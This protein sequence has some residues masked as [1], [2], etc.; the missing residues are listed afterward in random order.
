MLVPI[1]ILMDDQ[2][3]SSAFAGE[4][5]TPSDRWK[6]MMAKTMVVSPL[7]YKESSSCQPVLTLSI[8]YIYIYIYNPFIFPSLS[9]MQT[10]IT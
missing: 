9:G 5:A 4:V 8:A 2:R 7:A 3:S 10:R 6:W 1:V